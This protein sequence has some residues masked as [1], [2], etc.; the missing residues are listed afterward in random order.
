M[1]VFSSQVKPV[2]NRE[3]IGMRS[4]CRR[5]G[6]E[7]QGAEVS[8]SHDRGGSTGP[9]SSTALEKFNLL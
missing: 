3:G 5:Q 4:S 2:L 1:R 6:V 8:A 7:A 9:M